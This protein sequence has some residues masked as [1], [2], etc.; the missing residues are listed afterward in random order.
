[1]VEQEITWVGLRVGDFLIEDTIGQGA[2]SSVFR[3]VSPDGKTLAAF[4]VSKPRDQI[5]MQ[6]VIQKDPSQ[7]I[8]FFTGGIQGIHPD[9]VELLKKQTE[10]MRASGDDAFPRVDKLVAEEGF[11]YYQ[12]ELL[13]GHTLR[14]QLQSNIVEVSTF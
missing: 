5:S 8:G 2:F 14:A 4:K 12:M 13:D 11:G 7:A 9:S 6:P 1:M 3:G 10:K